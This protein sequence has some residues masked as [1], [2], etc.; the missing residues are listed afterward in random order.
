MVT[1]SFHFTPLLFLAPEIAKKSQWPN[2]GA[3]QNG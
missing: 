3:A 2:L 1:F